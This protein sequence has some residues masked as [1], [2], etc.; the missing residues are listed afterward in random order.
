MARHFK[1]I[2]IS[3]DP[4][5]LPGE[6]A[7]E[8]YDDGLEPVVGHSCGDPEDPCPPPA[9]PV[10]PPY[11]LFSDC[12][13]KIMVG[14]G[15]QPPNEPARSDPLHTLRPVP[16][17]AFVSTKVQCQRCHWVYGAWDRNDSPPEPLPSEARVRTSA[18]IMLASQG[19]VV[20]D[21]GVT[22]SMCA[23]D[24]RDERSAA[25]RLSEGTGDHNP[26]GWMDWGTT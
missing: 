26:T 5:R 6:M 8:V 16:T 23:S 3:A 21:D 22:C 12:P 2:S 13:S 11:G 18:M 24:G 9:A 4:N 19:F 15:Y 17:F 20:G 10:T 25:L 1:P 7:L 14:R